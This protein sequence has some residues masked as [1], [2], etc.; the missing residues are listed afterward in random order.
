MIHHLRKKDNDSKEGLRG[1]AA[2]FDNSRWVALL[3]R[4]YNGVKVRIIKNNYLPMT[5]NNE[6]TVEMFN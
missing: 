4:Y 1:A 5:N 3:H 2:L 6:I